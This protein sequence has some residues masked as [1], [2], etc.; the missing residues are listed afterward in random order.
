MLTVTLALASSDARLSAN[1]SNAA[2]AAAD[3]G[4]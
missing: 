2:F 1:A 3:A 4:K